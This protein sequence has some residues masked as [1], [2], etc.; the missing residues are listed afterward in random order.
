VGD[1]SDG[2]GQRRGRK[3]QR[4]E[5]FREHG[6]VFRH[7]FRFVFEWRLWAFLIFVLRI[8]REFLAGQFLRRTPP[9]VFFLG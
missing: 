6:L 4:N 7:E 8:V 5:F 9:P 1:G 2:W 3:Q